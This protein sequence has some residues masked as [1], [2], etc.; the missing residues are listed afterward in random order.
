MVTYRTVE[1][2]IDSLAPYK[3]PV[4]DGV[5]LALLQEG[6]EVVIPYLVRIFCACMATGYV[7]TIWLQV[8]IVFIP[9][10]GRSSY[11]GPRDYRPIS[12]TSFLLKTM[13]R[14]VD[15]YLRDEALALVP[16]HPNQHAHQAGK[17]VET[18]LH[19]LVV[20]VEKV[21]NQQETALG[22]FLNI[23]GA[24][25]N[26]C[27][28][29]MC[30]AFVRRGSEYTIVWWIRATLEGCVVVANLISWILCEARDIQGLPTGG[31]AVTL[32]WCLVVDDLLA[33][34]S[35][36]DVFI[37]AYGDTMCLLAVSKFP[38]TV[39]GLMQWALSTVETWCNEGRLSV[40]PDKTGLIAFTRKR[41]LPS[42]FE[43]QF[44]GVKLSLLGSVKYLGVILDSR[45]T[46]REHVGV[47][48]RKAHS[49]LWA[50]R[51]TCG[52]R[53]GQRPKVVHQLYFAIVWLTV[54]FA[55]LVLWPGCQTASAKKKLS[56][57]QRLA[58]LGITGPIRTTPTSAMEALVGLPPLD[59][60]IQGE[61]RSVAHH[62]WS[63]GSWS[64]LHPQQGHSCILTRLQESDPIFKM[65]VD[66][67]KPVFN[68]EPRYRVTMLTREEWIRGPGTPPAVKGLIWFKDGSR[69]MEGTRAGVYGQSA[70]RRLSISLGKHTTVFQ[71]EVYAI[72]ACVHEIETQDLPEKYVSICSDS[73][74]ALKVLQAGKTMSP[75]VRQC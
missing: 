72:L 74:A 69:T 3:S 46:W 16:L 44:F 41:T 73:Q 6:R 9:K 63:L 68:L 5:F 67:M 52:A 7:P 30:D 75:L 40:N 21:L 57:V 27:C 11:S 47:K 59:L 58:C 70:D 29:A 50:C 36:S 25:N 15:R 1:W 65:G 48:A 61:A 33:R 39:S 55:S 66:V 20:W 64:Y 49:L 34:L 4:V 10:P 51:R 18:A 35:G 38:N 23:E 31:H 53:W 19:Q 14:L 24:F 45:L 43:P 62:L 42:F 13:E 56:K 8:K 54:S 32:L 26:T 60:L 2:S 17:S 37:Q 12:L 71:A 22:V 28:D